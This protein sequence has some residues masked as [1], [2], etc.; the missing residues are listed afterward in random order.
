ME[1]RDLLDPD[2]AVAVA[3]MPEAALD[4]TML[5]VEDWLAR[6]IRPR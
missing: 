5:G 4:T 1:P 6:Q 3:H 2:V